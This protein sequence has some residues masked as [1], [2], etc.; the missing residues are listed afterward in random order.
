MMLKSAMRLGAMTR[1]AV[2]GGGGMWHKWGSTVAPGMR[3]V[4]RWTAGRRG[5]IGGTRCRR[6][7]TNSGE[8]AAQLD[9]SSEAY[10]YLLY[11]KDEWLHC[12]VYVFVFFTRQ[13]LCYCAIA[14]VER[15]LTQNPRN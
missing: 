7:N 10:I 6:G 8:C 5:L 3:S 4:G 14:V 2:R 9:A 12:T 11:R 13:A 1:G 15:D